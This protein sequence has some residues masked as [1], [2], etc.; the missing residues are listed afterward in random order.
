MPGLVVDA[1]EAAATRGI[2]S[3]RGK[4]GYESTISAMAVISA[5]KWGMGCDGRY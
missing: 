3:L 2:Y 1:G 5:G 4:T